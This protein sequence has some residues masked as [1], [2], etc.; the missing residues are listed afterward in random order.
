[1]A[2]G[3]KAELSSA[4]SAFGVRALASDAHD[5]LVAKVS[6]QVSV[7][8]EVAPSTNGG[9]VA[10]PASSSRHATAD[11]PQT[12]PG[13]VLQCLRAVAPRWRGERYVLVPKWR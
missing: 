11:L 3:T 7:C 6:I 10:P 5:F 9:L 2:P 1:M 8:N 13:T 12:A 4:K